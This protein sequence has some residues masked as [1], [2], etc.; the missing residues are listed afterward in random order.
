MMGGSVSHIATA[1]VHMNV[2]K[3]L[4][5]KGA[6]LNLKNN[7]GKTRTSKYQTQS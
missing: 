6:T 2:V 4:V 5:K 3:F 1:E 7:K